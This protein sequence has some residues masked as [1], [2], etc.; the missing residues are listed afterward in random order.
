[1]FPEESVTL[2]SR[3]L[4]YDPPVVVLSYS[5]VTVP[6]VTCCRSHPVQD[7]VGVG[8]G[9]AS[10]I[11][12]RADVAGVVVGKRGVDHPLHTGPA[13]AG[14]VARLESECRPGITGMRRPS[15]SSRWRDRHV[16]ARPV[17]REHLAAG[18]TSGTYDPRQD[19]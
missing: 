13:W 2:V 11:R 5:Y 4:A 14:M 3:P 10:S 16:G 18:V 19:L 6:S 7:V 17:D 8:G 1:V 9:R 12:L 15:A